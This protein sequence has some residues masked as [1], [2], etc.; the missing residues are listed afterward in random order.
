MRLLTAVFTYTCLYGC[1]TAAAFSLSM[2]IPTTPSRRSFISKTLS[3]TTAAIVAA[4]GVAVDKAVAAPEIFTTKKGVKYAVLK[5]GKE[6]TVL[7]PSPQKGDFVAIEYTG[8]LTDG[9]IFDGTHAEGKNKALFFELGGNAVIDGINDMVMQMDVGQKVQAI[10]PPELAFGDKGIC[11]EESGDCLVKPK[12][13]L[14]YD[15][16]LKTS[17][18]PPP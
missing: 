6:G 9:R 16:L 3:T 12:S 15:I 1:K 17:A 14:V 13:T 18:V 7:N 10:I 5:K 8:Y 2:Q 4:S 11:I